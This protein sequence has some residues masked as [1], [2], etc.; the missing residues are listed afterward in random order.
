M[1]K[2]LWAAAVAM[3]V[4]GVAQA[5]LVYSTDFTT[6]YKSGGSGAHVLGGAAADVAAE[7]WFGSTN[8]V[9]LDGTDLTLNNGSQNRYRGAGVWLDATGWATGL[10]TVEI[11]VA[12]YV[13]GADTTFSFETYAAN[14]VDSANSVSMDLHA[15][16]SAGA[17]L[18]QTGSATI[19]QFGTEQTVTADGTATFTFD[20]NGSDDY[21][22]LVFAQRNAEGG[23]AF[24]YVDFD[25]LTVNTIPEPA[26]LGMLGFGAVL[27][28]AIRRKMY[29]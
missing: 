2:I 17:G 22:A 13:A 28:L 6:G 4:S 16:V 3:M 27:A 12:N 8:G 15:G 9:N 18:A 26:T 19:A 7:D 1:K 21:V 23:T 5:A 29:A 10:V 25:N 20:Y 24:G 14:G 11:D